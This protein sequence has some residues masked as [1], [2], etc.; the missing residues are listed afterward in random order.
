[1]VVLFLTYSL[2]YWFV[3][4]RWWAQNEVSVLLWMW[5]SITVMKF[6]W[7]ILQ[8]RTCQTLGLY[9]Q[10]NKFSLLSF[11]WL[12]QCQVHVPVCV[13]LKQK[14][15]YIIAAYDWTV[16]SS[17]LSPTLLC[18]AKWKWHYWIVQHQ[19]EALARVLVVA[20]LFLKFLLD[21]LSLFCSNDVGFLDLLRRYSWPRN[22][23]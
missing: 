1:V 7:Y 13:P 3:K 17:R 21:A 18:L 10:I 8:T 23:C 12:V 5:G 16:I 20:G 19:R 14:K 4:V 2:T 9:V 15:S 22:C 11:V 6:L